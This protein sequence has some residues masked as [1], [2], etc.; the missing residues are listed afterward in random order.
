M[1][2]GTKPGRAEVDGITIRARV[3]VEDESGG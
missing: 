2:A 3:R 1:I